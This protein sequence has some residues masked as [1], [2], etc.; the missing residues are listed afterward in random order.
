MGGLIAQRAAAG[1]KAVVVAVTDGEAAEPSPWSPE[2]L[3][4]IRRRE[5]RLALAELCAGD[6]PV[7][8]LGL[9]DGRVADHTGRL[10]AELSLVARRF[11]VIVGPW[12]HDHHADHEVIGATCRAVARTAG[13]PFVAGLSWAWVRQSPDRLGG[14][15]LRRLPLDP[16]MR[17]RR[18][19][20]LEQHCSQLRLASPIVPPELAAVVEWDS[21][22][23]VMGPETQSE[24]LR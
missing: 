24:T 6:T 16:D 9:P 4:V 17:A 7:V 8:R 23:F 19:S 3:M 1:G 21:E 20:A 10:E 13:L 2:E 18:R 22:F 12:E 15:Q 5:Q 11:D 14:R